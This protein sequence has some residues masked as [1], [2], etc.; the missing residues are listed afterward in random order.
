MLWAPFL[1]TAAT[2]E[3]LVYTERAWAD[4]PL[5]NDAADAFTLNFATL[6]NVWP[7]TVLAVTAAQL[8]VW[9]LSLPVPTLR[10]LRWVV[11][12]GVAVLM[13]VAFRSGM[14]SP[15]VQPDGQ[16]YERFPS[17]PF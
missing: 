1:A 12:V 11:P 16:C 2:Y 6:T 5:G 3:G 13:G 7:V 17:V 10:W 9:A 4:C 14:G 15:H 8:S